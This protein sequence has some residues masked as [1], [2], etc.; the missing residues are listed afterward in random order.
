ML[1]DTR[2]P[3]V[4]RLPVNG[5]PADGT[6]GRTRRGGTSASSGAR[7]GGGAWG[8]TML[9]EAALVTY[10]PLH[11]GRPGCP[12]LARVHDIQVWRL[13]G[14]TPPSPGWTCAS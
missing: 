14:H 1:D 12:P 13:L 3:R 4:R 10:A 2:G 11:G 8:F 9:F 5:Q 7:V 6:T